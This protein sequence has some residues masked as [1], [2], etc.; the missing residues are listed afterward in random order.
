M[1]RRKRE[2]FVETK[3]LA[4]EAELRPSHVLWLVLAA[5]VIGGLLYS[6]ALNGWFVF[7]DEGLPFRRGIE[8][9]SLLIWLGGLRPLLRFSYWLNFG[10]SG[11]DPYGY[12]IV[13]LL[14]HA[15]NTDRKSVV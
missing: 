13:N 5:T 7:D 9:E 8:D 3:S 14:I 1:S 12:H 11:Q 2:V 4:R 15:T 10:I 6:S